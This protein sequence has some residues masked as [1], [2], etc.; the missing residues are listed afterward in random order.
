MACPQGGTC[1]GR[2][3]HS[4]A[5]L[6]L[7]SRPPPPQHPL[8]AGYTILGG[9]YLRPPP[10]VPPTSP[11][12]LSAPG[13]VQ[14]M[15]RGAQRTFKCCGQGWGHQ[16][17]GAWCPGAP[18]PGPRKGR[19]RGLGEGPAPCAPHPPQ[20]EASP[21]LTAGRASPWTVQPKARGHREP[22]TPKTRVAG[23]EGA[24]GK[25]TSSTH[26]CSVFS[27]VALLG[28][29]G[30][31]LPTHLGTSCDLGPSISEVGKTAEPPA[32]GR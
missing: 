16:Q 1:Q 23:R 25:R 14:Q 27:R 22:S 32:Q 26:L 13:R 31:R 11:Y 2:S 29:W 12:G 18:P 28:V 6:V 19:K 4:S 21:L 7:P 15:C 9:L 20:A 8:G 30:P 17:K 3:G 5:P 10:W 24:G